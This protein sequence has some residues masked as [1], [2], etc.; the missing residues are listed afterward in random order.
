MTNEILGYR[1]SKERQYTTFISP[2]LFPFPLLSISVLFHSVMV[3]K[4]DAHLRFCKSIFI[5]LHT[6]VYI[7]IK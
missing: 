3:A 7:S 2:F 5:N 1:S 4:V 6:Y